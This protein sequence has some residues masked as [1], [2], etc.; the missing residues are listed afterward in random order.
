M[1]L[2]VETYDNGKPIIY[3]LNSMKSPFGVM[4]EDTDIQLD[5]KGRK[6]VQEG[7]FV[8]GVGNKNRFL[9]R[10]RIKTAVTTSDSTVTLK[11]PSFSFMA[12]DVLYG[13][14][15]HARINLVG[16]PTAT[17]VI[18]VCVDGMNYST[19]V[20]GSPTLATTAAQFVTDNAADLLADKNVVITSDGA[21]IKLVGTD[22]HSIAVDSSNGDLQLIVSTTIPGYLGDAV[23]PFGTILSVGA[24]NAEGERVV[25]LAATAAYDLPV[26]AVLGVMVNEDG[27]LGIY[28]EPLDFTKTPRQALAPIY[29]ADGVYEKNLPYI[30]KQLKRQFLQLNI[31]KGFYKNS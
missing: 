2:T 18:T 26:D 11:V 23:L 20:P 7:M 24:A 12:G 1:F 19:T 25:T 30:D 4:I 31:K 14:S 29:G 22:S 21:T 6:N 8:V 17:E 28:P 3:G 10:T 16:S 27:Y 15:G 13:K 9:P 5:F